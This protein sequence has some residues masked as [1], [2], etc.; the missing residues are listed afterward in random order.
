[1]SMTMTIT[2]STMATAMAT[3]A[4]CDF[5]FCVE[6]LWFVIPNNELSCIHELKRTFSIRDYLEKLQKPQK[7]STFHQFQITGAT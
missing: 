1:M 4:F 5:A 2:M 6:Q 3:I 7:M